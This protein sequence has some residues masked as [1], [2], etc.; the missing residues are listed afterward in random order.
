MCASAHST[1]DPFIQIFPEPEKAISY[2]FGTL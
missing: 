1:S 2:S